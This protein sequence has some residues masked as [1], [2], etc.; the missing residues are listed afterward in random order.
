M[1]AT[2]IRRDGDFYLVL[3][4]WTGQ[5]VRAHRAQFPW[6]GRIEVG[7]ELEV[8]VKPVLSVEGICVSKS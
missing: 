8:E 5:I 4:L 3:R 2:V 7:T 6:R 1:Q